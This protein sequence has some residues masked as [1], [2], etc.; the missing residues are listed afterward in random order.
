MQ[1]QDLVWTTSWLTGMQLPYP[2]LYF[3]ISKISQKTLQSADDKKHC[4]N[5]LLIS[6]LHFCCIIDYHL[7]Q[8]HVFIKLCLYKAGAYARVGQF[9]DLG[10]H[11]V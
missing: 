3:A 7:G 4:D 5:T 8:S 6:V 2:T 1:N 10:I 11:L 9:K